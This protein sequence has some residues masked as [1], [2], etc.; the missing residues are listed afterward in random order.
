MASIS[1]SPA[2]AV[3]NVGTAETY[4]A[5]G[6]DAD[7]N[8][9]GSVTGATTFTISPNGSCTGASCSA[10][11]GGSHT[12]TGTDGSFHANAHLTVTDGTLA[13][14]A[15][16]PVIASVSFGASET[17]SAQGYDAYGDS[18]AGVTG[19]TTFT[20]A[21]NGIC[22]G[23]SCSATVAGV[24]TV[25]GTDGLFH[26]NAS[27]TV[28]LPPLVITASSATMTY[29]GTVPTI[30][31]SYSGF[32][33]GD[34]ASSLTTA[35]SCST[36]ATSSSLVGTY[37][38]SCSG[39]VDPNYTIS[40]VTGLVTVQAASGSSFYITTTSL[41]P[42]SG[43]IGSNYYA[44]QLHATGGITPYKWKLIG[45]LLPKGIK[46]TSSGSLIGIPSPRATSG[47]YS[48]A[49]QVTD[50]GPK[51]DGGKQIKTQA[52]TVTLSPTTAT[53]LVHGHKAG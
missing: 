3:A 41:P 8:S 51:K 16:S 38:S 2:S 12:V 37:R 33:N 44:V 4:I 27:L 17:Y 20:I 50:H 31:P 42:I 25:T 15:L 24:H 5:T 21:P 34:S 18:L 7:G 47:L 28:G 46:L 35:P 45:G 10:T 11:V 13:S 29:S 39:A 22:I 40:Y 48:F 49:V 19:S 43:A 23:S 30:T 52:L 26:A 6:S 1:L 14:I 36:A 9:L 32:V 53:G